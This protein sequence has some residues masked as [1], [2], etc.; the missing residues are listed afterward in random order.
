LPP[1]EGDRREAV[2]ALDEQDSL[3]AVTTARENGRL[4]RHD[5][6]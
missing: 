6:I 1:G 3:W 4:T 5:E 2:A